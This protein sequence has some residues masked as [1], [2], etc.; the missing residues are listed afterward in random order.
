MFSKRL[1][2]IKMLLQKKNHAQIKRKK[3]K[4]IVTLQKIYSGKNCWFKKES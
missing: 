2:A 3:G 4:Q 1:V